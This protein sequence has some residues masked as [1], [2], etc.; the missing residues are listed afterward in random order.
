MFG[1]VSEQGERVFCVPVM[2]VSEGEPEV[3]L[4]ETEGVSKVPQGEAEGVS[5]VPQGETEGVSKVPQDETEGASK[6][7]LCEEQR[8][9][10]RG[11]TWIIFC[12][13]LDKTKTLL[14]KQSRIWL[15]KKKE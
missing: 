7:P 1:S 13:W 4:G 11:R 9:P 3:L 12:L 5:K 2:L 10:S 6:V 15:R 14:I 8:K